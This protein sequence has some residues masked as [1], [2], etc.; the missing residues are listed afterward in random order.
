[1]NFHQTRVSVETA[2]LP[3]DRTLKFGHPVKVVCAF[4]R[5]RPIPAGSR[6]RGSLRLKS[7]KVRKE[8]LNFARR[9]S[10]VGA[11]RQA[12]N[13]KEDVNVRYYV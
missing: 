9:A 1:M 3:L 7:Y 11:V 13:C 12:M 2:V 4:L 5:K 10:E 6:G 8:M